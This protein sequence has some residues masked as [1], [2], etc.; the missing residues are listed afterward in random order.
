[1]VID[2]G[3]GSRPSH[4]RRPQYCTM[5]EIGIFSFN[6]PFGD[7]LRAFAL[8]SAST[9][10]QISR[11][12]RSRTNGVQGSV[13]ER[14]KCHVD[15]PHD[16]SRCGNTGLGKS[17]DGDYHV[18]WP[19]VLERVITAALYNCSHLDGHEKRRTAKRLRQT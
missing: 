8:D 1:M 4:K 16:I 18:D 15:L 6:F 19:T 10:K 7:Y 14:G 3:I 5:H 11:P 2:F 13:R 9:W 17:M 12:R